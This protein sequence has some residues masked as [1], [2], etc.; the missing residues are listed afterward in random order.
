M[1]RR[2]RINSSDRRKIAQGKA[3]V[4]I[5]GFMDTKKKNRKYL[6]VQKIYTN[7]IGNKDNK[8]S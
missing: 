1:K 5:S 8:V 4:I 2:Q 6:L 7:S 3:I